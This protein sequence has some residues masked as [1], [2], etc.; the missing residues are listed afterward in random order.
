MTSLWFHW[1][2]MLM[3]TDGCRSS[4][5]EWFL[6]EQLYDRS[7]RSCAFTIEWTIPIKAKKVKFLTGARSFLRDFNRT[8]WWVRETKGNAVSHSHVEDKE[9]FLQYDER[10]RLAI[11]HTSVKQNFIVDHILRVFSM[12]WRQENFDSM[13]RRCSREGDVK[14]TV[15]ENRIS[16]VDTDSI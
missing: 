7:C 3:E 8:S 13:R 4:G 9:D 6:K 11:L 5:E 14:L 15:C 1:Y 10:E 2:V 16:K 12:I